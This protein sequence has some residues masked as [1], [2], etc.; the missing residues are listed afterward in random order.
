MDKAVEFF[1]LP[2]QNQLA[3]SG[4]IQIRYILVLKSLSYFR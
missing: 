3:V 1:S 4:I 2:A